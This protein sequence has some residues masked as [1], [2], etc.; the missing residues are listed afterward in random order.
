MS[1]KTTVAHFCRNVLAELKTFLQF[2]PRLSD[3]IRELETLDSYP[4]QDPQK[5]PT[6]PVAKDHLSSALNGLQCA[7]NLADA[8]RSLAGILRW[9][10]IMQGDAIEPSLARGL[11]AGQITGQIGFTNAP[12]LKAGLFLLAPGI[13]YPLHQHAA[14]ELYFVLSGTLTL[15]HGLDGEPFHVG[16][17]EFS[18]TPSSRLHALTTTEDPCLI[19]YTWIGDIEAPNWWWKQDA[20]GNWLRVCWERAPDASWQRSFS[21]AVTEDVLRDAAEQ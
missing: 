14:R 10:E 7:Q 2:E 15:Q 18:I 11:V 9:Y 20:D 21:E 5:L 6:P 4:F 1:E 12:S 17:G 3:F 19:F 16:P 8:T 13:H